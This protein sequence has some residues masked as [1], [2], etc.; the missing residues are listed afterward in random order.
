M[1][2]LA[3]RSSPLNR[4]AWCQG[5]FGSSGTGVRRPSCQAAGRTGKL[6]FA[7]APPQ[8]SNCP[9]MTG[10]YLVF[11]RYLPLAAASETPPPDNCLHHAASP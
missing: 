5:R 2:L 4:A 8:S 3:R 10:L 1:F 9:L 11:D 6:P 7:A